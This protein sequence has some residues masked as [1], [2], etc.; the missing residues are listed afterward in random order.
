MNTQRDEERARRR[1]A[2]GENRIPPAAAVLVAIG[3]YAEPCQVHMGVV[4]IKGLTLRTGQANVIGH[5]DRVLTMLAAGTLDPTPLVTQHMALE[6]A[7]EGYAIY[8]RREA[9]KIVLRP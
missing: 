4:W 8:D 2:H 9:L 5:V 7:A 1:V 3:V 6:D